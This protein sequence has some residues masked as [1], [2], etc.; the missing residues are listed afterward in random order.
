MSGGSI[1]SLL[2]SP[3]S[4]SS[5]PPPRLSSPIAPPSPSPKKKKFPKIEFSLKLRMILDSVKGMVYLHSF[6]PPIIH[7]DLK[8]QNLLVRSCERERRRSRKRSRG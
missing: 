3:P 1:Y 2:H 6:E 8:S 4:S 5:P 7:R